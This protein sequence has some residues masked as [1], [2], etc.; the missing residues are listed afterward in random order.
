MLNVNATNLG[1]LKKYL[2]GGHMT[3]DRNGT[4][5][6]LVLAIMTT[7]IQDEDTMKTNKNLKKI[8]RNGDFPL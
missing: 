7:T 1:K 6:N 4:S 2:W 5:W 8:I 3:H